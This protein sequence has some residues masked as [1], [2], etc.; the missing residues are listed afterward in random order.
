MLAALR[1]KRLNSSYCT[2]SYLYILSDLERVEEGGAAFRIVVGRFG[3]GRSFF[4]NLV[5]FVEKIFDRSRT[6]VVSPS[7]GGEGWGEG[8]RYLISNA[9]VPK[10]IWF[11]TWPC[12]SAWWSFLYWLACRVHQSFRI[13]HLAS[14]IPIWDYIRD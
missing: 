1:H 14:N 6:D 4:M 10:Q 7:P 13:D 12:K 5:Y 8:E 2:I 9:A 11:V 3:S